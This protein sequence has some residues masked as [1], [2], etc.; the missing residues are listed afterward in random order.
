MDLKIAP[1]ILGVDYGRMNEH[2]AE[3]APFSDMFHVDVMDGNFV[4]NLTVGAPVVARIKTKVPLDCHLMINNPHK[5]IKDFAEAGA[6]SITIHAEA[7]LHLGD[8]IQ[9]IK[10]AGCRAAVALNPETPVDKISKVLPMLDMVLI[11]SVHPGFGGQA[12]I[13][14]VLEKV[15]WLREHYPNLDIQIDGGINDQTA[16]LAKK[17]GANVLVAGSYI[18]KNKNPAGA[19]QKLRDA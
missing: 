6:Y 8:D 11:M 15:K 9:K 2:L 3:L 5:F 16:P 14:E 12:F 18:L 7:S 19:A 13:P 1:S 17:A 10:D 4:D